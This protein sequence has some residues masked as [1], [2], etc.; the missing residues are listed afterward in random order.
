MSG[1]PNPNVLT[2]D[3]GGSYQLATQDGQSIPV[4]AAPYS[5]SVPVPGAGDPTFVY[6]PGNPNAG[7]LN[8]YGDWPSLMAAVALVPGN[9]WIQIDGS[10]SQPTGCTVPAGNWHVNNCTFTSVSPVGQSPSDGVLTFLPGAS[11]SFLLLTL[12]GPYTVFL[13]TSTASVA[14]LN[15]QTVIVEDGASLQ[16]GGGDAAP[17]FTQAATATPST[18][19]LQDGATLGDG[20]HT[21]VTVA[22]ACLLNLTVLSGSVVEANALGGAG[23][24]EIAN[25]VTATIAAPQNQVVTETEPVGLFPG[26]PNSTWN[27]GA[28]FIDPVNGNDTNPG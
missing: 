21:V 1:G 28:W 15:A 2:L 9:K 12:Q 14:S 8:F 25:D 6:S 24:Y 27:Q 17:F 11:L 18:I 16:T 13:N 19:I 4:V 3:L 22:T 23:T 5:G 10:F 26:L 7:T 20:E